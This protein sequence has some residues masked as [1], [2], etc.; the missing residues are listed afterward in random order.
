MNGIYNDTSVELIFM[1]EKGKQRFVK[2]RDF[3][4]T[5]KI[6]NFIAE[7]KLVMGL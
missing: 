4:R 3:Y 5:K 1:D 7:T 6:E 2:L